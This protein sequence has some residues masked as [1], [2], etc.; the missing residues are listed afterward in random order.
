MKQTHTL[1]ALLVTVLALP[2]AAA[3]QSD[4]EAIEKIVVTGQKS[5]SELRRDLWKYEDE[6]YSLYNQLNDDNNYD[7]RCS[8]EAPTGSHIKTQVCRPNFLLKAIR[9]GDITRT[10]DL[11][12][13]PV[14]AEEMAT[15]REKR[16]ALIVANPDLYA[17][18]VA[19]STAR[20]RIAARSEKASNN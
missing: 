4:D 12:T 8:R 13:S 17:A 16:D 6:F 7:V 5:M 18:A 19:F 11:A 15:F 9:R 3:G 1:W 14:I 10:K 2:I 20:T